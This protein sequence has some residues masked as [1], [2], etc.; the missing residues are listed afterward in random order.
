MKKTINEKKGYTTP[1]ME[2]VRLE[3]V[4]MLNSASAV[5]GAGEASDIGYGGLGDDE[6]GD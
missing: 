1:L 4:P 5:S 2:I 6:Y 3:T